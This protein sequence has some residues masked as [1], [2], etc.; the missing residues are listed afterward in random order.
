M[1]CAIQ[2]KWTFSGPEQVLRDA[3]AAMAMFLSEQAPNNT[4]SHIFIP[5]VIVN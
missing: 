3:Y 5:I 4:F 1:A 2:A